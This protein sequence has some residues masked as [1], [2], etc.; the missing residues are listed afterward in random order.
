MSYLDFESKVKWEKINLDLIINSSSHSL[1]QIL[2]LSFKVFFS[3]FR[4]IG[5]LFLEDTRNL[6]QRAN[7]SLTI[8]Q[9]SL[10]KVE[11]IIRDVKYKSSQWDRFGSE[12]QNPTRA[13]I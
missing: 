7:N 2:Q 5:A 8:F 9:D 10:S 4:R 3:K 12:D 11:H 13:R 1:S 6:S